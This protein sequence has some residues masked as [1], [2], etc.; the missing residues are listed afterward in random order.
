MRIS[1][2][3]RMGRVDKVKVLHGT[4]VVFEGDHKAE[5]GVDIDN[6]TGS[7]YRRELEAPR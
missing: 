3:L 6:C 4:G 1:L 5:A 2:A 7:E